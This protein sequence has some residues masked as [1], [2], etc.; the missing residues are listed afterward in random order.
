[1]FHPSRRV[2][3]ISDAH[4]VRLPAPPP[5]PDVHLH[6][7]QP[8]KRQYPH[9]FFFH[10]PK[11]SQ[12]YEGKPLRIRRRTYTAGVGM[13]APA[14]LRYELKAE[15]D[16]FVALAGVDDHLTDASH[17]AMKAMHPSV[18]FKV[19][20]DG[21]LAAES[22][23]MRISQE[24]WRFN[25]K[26]PQGSRRI[27]LAATD[28]GSRS[29]YDLANWA[30]AGFLLKGWA[31]RLPTLRVPG[32]WDRSGR[33]PTHDGFAW[34]RCF[35]IVPK[36]WAGRDLTLMVPAV[37][38]CH[39][40][41][42]N[43]RKVGAAGSMPPNYVNGLDSEKPCTI[44][45]KLVRPGEWNLLAVR[46][47]DAGGAGGFR[48]GPPTVSLGEQTIKLEGRWLFHLGDKPEWAHWPK[49]KPA[50]AYVT[51]RQAK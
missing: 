28:A 49:D 23:V 14:N 45:A 50:P 38:N 19:Y 43:G 30:D 51:F 18:V 16:R 34:Y 47:Y 32:Y 29:P 11:M 33:Y 13:R 41:Y 12:S 24:P 4:F 15:Y 2:S 7:I 42:F 6:E 26:V 22:P 25:V 8:M 1:M 36:A 27:N 48:D 46:V 39:E 20:I 44:P 9:K 35:V 10:F 5:A 3:L 31:D 40:S 21:A 17:G 37:D